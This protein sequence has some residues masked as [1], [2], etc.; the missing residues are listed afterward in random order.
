MRARSIFSSNVFVIPSH[1]AATTH[2]RGTLLLAET[3]AVLSVADARAGINLV[4]CAECLGFATPM[5]HISHFTLQQQV[6]WS[7][8]AREVG[9]K[10][11][12]PVWVAVCTVSLILVVVL[13]PLI[14][15]QVCM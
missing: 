4:C 13:L 2:N 3:S 14:P 15:K 12:D 7:A 5:F 1:H 9:M 6:A 11:L 8:N 10:F